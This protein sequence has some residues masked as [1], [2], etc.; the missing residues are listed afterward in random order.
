MEKLL[1]SKELAKAIG[2]SESSMRRWTNSGVIRT[3]RTVGGHRRIAIS[4]AIRF[5]RESGATVVRPELLGLPDLPA[6][7]GDGTPGGPPLEV[8][9]FDALSAGDAGTVRGCVSALLL[10]GMNVASICDGAL[11]RAM[12]RIG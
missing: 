8:R 2:A 6:A 12:L 3:A 4:E 9:L 1:T 11:Q 5:V 7:A 10:G